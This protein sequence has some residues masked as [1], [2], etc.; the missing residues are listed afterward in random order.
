MQFAN[1]FPKNRS[2][3]ITFYSGAF[4]ASAVIFVLLKYGYDFGLSFQW[5]CFTLVI[6]SL[7][8]IPVTFFLLPSQAVREEEDE[9]DDQSNDH[10]LILNKKY[11][12]KNNLALVSSTITLEKFKVIASPIPNKR[13]IG[14]TKINGQVNYGNTNEEISKSISTINSSLDEHLPPRPPS[15]SS[16]S[17]SSTS[18]ASS[19]DQVPL[20]QSLFSLPFSLHQWWYSWLITY[21][22]MYV[23]SMNLWLNRVTTDMWVRS[24]KYELF[25]FLLF[26]NAV[27]LRVT[28]AKY[29]EWSKFYV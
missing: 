11:H 5:T 14:S 4:S 24:D 12:A 29:L 20:K 15:S 1:L 28:S 8:M 19:I 26:Q 17:S 10:K 21:M 27:K 2:T 3:V 23:G 22:I 16:K 7:A 13:N 6:L 18:S 9:S 25:L